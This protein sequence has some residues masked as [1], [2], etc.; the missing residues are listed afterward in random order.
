MEEEGHSVPHG[1]SFFFVE[2]LPE[3]GVL[4]STCRL[5]GGVK[6]NF[7]FFTLW[8]PFTVYEKNNLGTRL[9]ANTC[10]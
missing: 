9:G 6:K 7:F 1:L 10:F 2:V 8:K 4:P 5:W 3:K